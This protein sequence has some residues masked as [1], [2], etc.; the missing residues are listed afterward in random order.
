M[1][2]TELDIETYFT[3]TQRKEKTVFLFSYEQ[4]E[5]P[6]ID[7]KTKFTVEFIHIRCSNKF[8]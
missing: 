5:V 7:L 8:Q 6:I 2:A 3:Q 4:S 1:T